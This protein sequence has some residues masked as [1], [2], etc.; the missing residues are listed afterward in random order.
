MHPLATQARPDDAR[1]IAEK[2][3][4]AFRDRPV[5]PEGVRPLKL[6]VSIGLAAWQPEADFDAALARADAALYAAKQGGRDG[7]RLADD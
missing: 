1:R 7:W 2:V 4:Q 6:T 3:C 5:Q